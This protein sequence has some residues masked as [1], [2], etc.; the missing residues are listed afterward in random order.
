MKYIETYCPTCG[1]KTIHVIWTEDGYGASGVARIFSTLISLGMANLAA[2]HTVNV[3]V[4]E[5]LNSY[6]YENTSLGR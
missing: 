4:V 5:K 2:L 1:E 6:N 3:L